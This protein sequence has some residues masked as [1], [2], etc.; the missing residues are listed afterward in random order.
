TI[1]SFPAYSYASWYQRSDDGWHFGGD[2]NY[3]TFAYS[4][5]VGPYSLPN[6]WYMEYNPRPTSPT[7]G[8]AWHLNDDALGTSTQS[9][10]IADQNGHSF[11]WDGAVNPMA[12]QWSKIELEIKYTSQ[13]DGYIKSWENGILRVDYRGKTDG[14]PGGTRTEGIGGYADNYPY[15]SNWRYFADVYLDYSRARVILGDAPT[16]D[17]STIREVQIPTLWSDASIDVTVNLGRFADHQ[18]AY[19]YVVN[20]DGVGNAVGI[21]ITTA[22]GSVADTTVPT[23]SVVQPA[24]G[25]VSGVVSVEVAASDDVGVAGV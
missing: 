6:N 9:L 10:Q 7:S 21:P 15:T 24:A 18:T 8:A 23:V 11:W 5:G 14:L 1:T 20:E 16:L 4:E 17:A 25:S 13:T 2:D 22:P 19:L 12:G 3:K